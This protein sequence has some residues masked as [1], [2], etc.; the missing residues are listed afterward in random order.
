MSGFMFGGAQATQNITPEIP[1]KILEKWKILIIDDEEDIHTVTKLVLSDFKFD[2]KE[3]EFYDAYSG[4]EAF[5]F[6]K[7]NPDI[8]LALVDVVMEDDHAGLNL[9]KRIRNELNNK[10]TRL[11]LRT[12]QPGQAPEKNIISDYDIN[13][14]KNKTELTDTKMH[15]LLFSSLRSYRD[16]IALERSRLGLEEVI[17][18]SAKIFE[19]KNL[20]QF[21]SAVLSQ[22]TSIL[23][24]SNDAAH[25]RFIDGVAIESK[26]DDFKVRAGLGKYEKSAGEVLPDDL[27]EEINDLLEKTL[28]AKTTQ[29]RDD[30]II[31]YFGAEGHSENLLYLKGSIELSETDKYLIDLF[32]TNVSIAF[33]NANLQKEIEDTQSE[34]IYLLGESVEN[35]SNE[36]G[37]HVKRVA[38]MSHCL[39]LKYG[40]SADEAYVI[41]MA[42]PLHDLGKIAI[43]DAILHKP[44]IHTDDEREIM[45]THVN[46]GFNMLKNSKRPILQCAAKIAGEHH[47]KW[48]GTGYPNG[49][50]GEEI[51]IAGRISAATD[52]F[53]ALVNSRCYKKAWPLEKV[54]DLFKEESG[55]HFEPKVVDCI[56]NNIDELMEIQ[57]VH[58]APT[59]H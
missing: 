7:E 30:C 27:K 24:F 10:N 55:K 53:D 4:A 57:R 38:E 2:G 46:L 33:D 15:T 22:L 31:A 41:K 59:D 8:A 9:I 3:L 45:K 40:L 32:C 50:K 21:A 54:L 23:G 25:L 36:T 11:V 16:I 52:V 5:D 34:V 17:R 48:D 1:S 6:L 18:S 14:Y 19:L 29:Y 43:P 35:R 49:L 12:G 56:I 20:S 42:S 39:A 13:D 58:Q 26:V 28:A 51:N 47:E 37:F 44:G